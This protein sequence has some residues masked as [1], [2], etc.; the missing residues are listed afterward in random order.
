MKQRTDIKETSEIRIY[1]TACV[2]SGV[3]RAVSSFIDY[4]S[5]PESIE[6]LYMVIDLGFI[7]GL[8]GFYSLYRQ[9]MS[10]LG[11]SG[12]I[13]S[14]CGFALIAGPE[15]KIFNVGIYQIGSPIIG[16]GILLLSVEIIR[17][18]LIGLVAPISLIASV[19]LGVASM[20]TGVPYL[21]T[22]TGILFGAGFVALG[23]QV[24]RSS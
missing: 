22:V 17:A 12:F 1:A 19:L 20:F 3:L 16:I 7:L 13:V 11:H 10:W 18:H 14:I 24:W 21:F 4:E 6:L 2:V 8:I 9:K 5:A 23:L 15:A